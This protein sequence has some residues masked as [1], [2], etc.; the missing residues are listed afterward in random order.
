MINLFNLHFINNTCSCS[1]RHWASYIPI[2][3][4][5]Y[6]Y[7]S[8]YIYLYLSIYIY[9]YIYIS[10]YIYIYIYISIYILFKAAIIIMCDS[11]SKIVKKTFLKTKKWVFNIYVYI[12]IYILH[13]YICKIPN[14]WFNNQYLK[15]IKSWENFSEFKLNGKFQN[16]K[17]IS[18]VLSRVQ[19]FYWM[20]EGCLLHFRLSKI[21]NVSVDQKARPSIYF[22]KCGRAFETLNRAFETLGRAFEGFRES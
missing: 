20:H 6:L 15:K 22:K 8:I 13:T 9:I 10:I 11:F 21:L 3:C 4:I 18:E 19:S 14:S 16:W 2:C 7:I 12:Y 17:Q 5:I 1:L